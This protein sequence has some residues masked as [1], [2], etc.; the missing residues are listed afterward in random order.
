MIQAGAIGYLLKDVARQELLTAIRAVALGQPWLHHAMHSQVVQLLRRKPSTDR[1]ATLSQRERSVLRLLGQGLSNRQIAE[2]LT[3]T[4]GTVKGYVSN[5]LRKL[6]LSQRTQAALLV[7][8]EP[9]PEE[10]PEE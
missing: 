10:L 5:L 4:E 7:A 6:N 9:V 8:R 3:L 2:A 1:Y